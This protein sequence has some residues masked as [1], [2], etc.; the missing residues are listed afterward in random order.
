MKPILSNYYV[1]LK[2]NSRCAFCNIWQNK[3]KINARLEDVKN[4]INHLKRIGVRAIDFTGGEPLLNKQLPEMLEYSKKKGFYN[5]LTTNAIN[6]PRYSKKI[7]PYV[8]ELLISIIS[9]NKNKHE[10]IHGKGS[11]NKLKESVKIAKEDGKKILLCYI[12]TNNNVK[13]LKSVINFAKKNKTIVYVSFEFSYFGNKEL[14]KRYLK[15]ISKYIFHTNVHFNL[16]FMKLKYDNGNKIKDPRCKAVSSTVTISPDN[17]LTLPCFHKSVKKI[18]LRN[19][20]YT[21][22][23][24][25]KVKELKEKEGK[26]KFCEGCNNNCYSRSSF[27]YKLDKYFILNIV[28]LINYFIKKNLI[29]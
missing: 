25:K 23:N 26:F 13:E 8:D 17:Y 15:E 20:L 22:W 14:N 10:K 19:N 27:F 1:T 28:S 11:F 12:L 29:K 21:I 2:C 24:S 3:K 5:I 6:Y 4:N 18:K 16:G 7:N 9:T